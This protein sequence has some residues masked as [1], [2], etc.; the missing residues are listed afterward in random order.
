M[1]IRQKIELD[2]LKKG[3]GRT[4]TE[5]GREERREKEE[6]GSTFASFK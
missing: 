6:G 3:R 4:T 5:E 2:T 1:S